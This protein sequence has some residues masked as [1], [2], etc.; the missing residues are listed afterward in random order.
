MNS[1]NICGSEFFLRLSKIITSTIYMVCH[2]CQSNESNKIICTD[3]ARGVSKIG[4]STEKICIRRIFSGTVYL[5]STSAFN[6]FPVEKQT[7]LSSNPNAT[8]SRYAS[9]LILLPFG[10]HELLATFVVN[11]TR[12]TINGSIHR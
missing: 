8:E 5:R 11:V 3:S 7:F 12:C 4:L 6:P 10:G 1:K 9:V 2:S